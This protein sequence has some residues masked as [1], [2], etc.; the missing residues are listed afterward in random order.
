M[1][2][3]NLHP[4]AD[5]L[6]VLLIA[7][8]SAAFVVSMYHLIATCLCN[9][10]ITTDQTHQPGQEQQPPQPASAPPATPSLNQYGS[11]SLAHMIPKHKYHKKKKA[12]GDGDED[13]TCAVCLGDF[14]EGEELRTLPECMH[15]FHV[16]CI[17][18]WLS[19]HTSCPICRASA[20]LS[21]AMLQHGCMLDFGSGDH[22]NEHHSINMMQIALVPSGLARR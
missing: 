17:D 12:D 18:M 20:T 21:P 11:S 6:V 5:N 16:P 8:G 7:M 15:S 19:S 4:F 14:E 13:G 2:G 3:E 9:H 1:D 22:L 10:H